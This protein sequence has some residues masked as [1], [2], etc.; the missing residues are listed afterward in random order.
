MYFVYS[1]KIFDMKY[2]FALVFTAFLFTLQAKSL[3]V[4]IDSKQFYAPKTGT[5]VELNMQFF[6]R[7]IHF[8]GD[9]I[10]G[11]SA[12][13]ATQIVITQ[14]EKVVQFD[15]YKIDQRFGGKDYV[16]DVYS[17][18]RFTLGPGTYTVEYDFIDLNNPKDTIQF[19]QEIEVT[20][21]PETAFFSEVL[22][23]E[24]LIKTNNQNAF[25]RNGFEMIPRLM[26]YYNVEAER[27]VAYVE[28]YNTHLYTDL[29]KFAVRYYLRDIQ[30]GRRIENY[31]TTKVYSGAEVIPLLVSLNVAELMTGTY[32]LTFE[33]LDADEQIVKK[34]YVTLERFN[35]T[36][37]EVTQDY[38]NV[39]LDPRFF[40]LLPNDSVFF[41]LESLTPISS[42]ADVTQIYTL[43]EKKDIE[44]AKKYFQAY[45]LRTNSRGATD[46]WL[47]YKQSVD[48]VQKEFGTVLLPGFKSDRG[49][50]FLQ[51]G[52]PN[53]KVQRPN[54]PGDYP[55]EIWQ[56]Y[57][58]GNFSNRRFVFY[59]PT[60]VGNEYVLLH[61]DMPG[62]L[63]N[64][65]WIQDVSRGG[66]S[67]RS[68][69]NDENI[70]EGGR[71]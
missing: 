63:F 29:P 28:L 23:L 39:I 69:I 61:S 42:R 14:D 58:I 6:A 45:W 18:K 3:R 27:L 20:R 35:P 25:V 36:R 71:R 33:F 32:D 54:E 68:R 62:E 12:S 10:Q 7:S 11:F 15:K 31:T 43:M 9:S 2:F 47:K 49:R 66:F 70:L 37:E 44:L 64:N 56:Y 30:N 52:P 1:W 22:L 8:K 65:R 17:L 19:S 60:S 67:G 40:E 26:N 21:A 50:V 53:A 51:Y 13:I 57:K 34:Q 46:A 4:M 41:Y 48:A 38:S 59:N 5:Y 55:Y 16:E 24:K